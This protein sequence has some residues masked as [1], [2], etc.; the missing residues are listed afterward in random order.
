M[1][2][3]VDQRPIHVVVADNEAEAIRYVITTYEP[4]PSLWDNDYR[5]RKEP[6]V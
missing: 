6:S 1:L 2:G 5:K 4:D 3:F